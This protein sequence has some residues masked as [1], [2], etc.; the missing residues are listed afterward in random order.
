MPG[1]MGTIVLKPSHNRPYTRTAFIVRLGRILAIPPRTQ[2][3]RN[4]SGAFRLD[5]RLAD[6]SRRS[7]RCRVMEYL[8]FASVA[9]FRMTRMK[10]RRGDAL[11]ALRRGPLRPRG[12]GGRRHIRFLSF[13]RIR[14]TQYTAP[15]EIPGLLE[16]SKRS[17]VCK[18][19]ARGRWRRRVSE[20]E[21]PH[22]DQ[23][24]W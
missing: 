23:I 21:D 20:T 14:N 6:L 16:M 3:A 5:S 2:E 22:P 17:L 24:R 7:R 1:Q 4:S 12:G 8:L 10:R 18:D 9:K 15:E 11:E 19:G 13:E